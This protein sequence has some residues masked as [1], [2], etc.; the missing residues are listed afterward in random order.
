MRKEEIE[1][2]K[3]KGKMKGGRRERWRKEGKGK[4]VR[5]MKVKTNE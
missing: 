4:D 2:G 1:E 5:E 3:K